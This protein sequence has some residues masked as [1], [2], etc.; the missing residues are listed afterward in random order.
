M[1]HDQ[2]FR[3]ISDRGITVHQAIPVEQMVPRHGSKQGL[4]PLRMYTPLMKGRLCPEFR[5]SLMGMK[6]L[7]IWTVGSDV[8]GSPWGRSSTPL[9]PPKCPRVRNLG[10]AIPKKNWIN[11]VC[12]MFST[13]NTEFCN[14]VEIV[15]FGK[16]RNFVPFSKKWYHGAE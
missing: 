10:R 9:D 7:A 6:L 1:A 3:M 13:C 12:P 5:S 8:F 11:L 15:Y 16:D 2:G 4:A 14:N